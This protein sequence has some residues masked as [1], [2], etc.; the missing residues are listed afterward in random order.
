VLDNSTTPIKGSKRLTRTQQITQQIEAKYETEKK[1][2]IQGYE[3]ALL[4]QQLH[5]KQ[6]SSNRYANLF[7]HYAFAGNTHKLPVEVKL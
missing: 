5:L 3:R 7:R 4:D 6:K 2:M 1:F